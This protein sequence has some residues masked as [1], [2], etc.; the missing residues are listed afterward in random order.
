MPEALPPDGDKTRRS[1]SF[2]SF[3]IVLVVLLLVLAVVGNDTFDRPAEL[4]QDRY[5][6]YLNKG[7]IVWQVYKPETET[8]QIKGEYRTAEKPNA[9]FQVNYSNLDGVE[10]RFR[11]L[12]SRVY[13]STRAAAF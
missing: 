11:E 8:I 7:D 5:E 1:R 9:K 12:R 3:L 6:W 10:E 13:T 4:S 2:G